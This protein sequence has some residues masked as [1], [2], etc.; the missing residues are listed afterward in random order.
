MTTMRR[1]ILLGMCPMP[2]PRCSGRSRFR[3]SREQSIQ[4]SLV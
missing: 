4:G 1:T 2:D 3:L